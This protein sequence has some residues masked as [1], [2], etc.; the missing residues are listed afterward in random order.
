MMWRLNFLV[1]FCCVVLNNSYMLYY[2]C[3]MH[4]LFTL[5]VYGALGIF[6]KYNEIGS[7]MAAKIIACFFVVILMWEIPG[8]FEVVWSPLT[9]IFGRYLAKCS[10]LLL[11]HRAAGG[12]PNASMYC[13]LYWSCKTRFAPLARVAFSFWPWSLYLDSWNDICLLSSNGK[14]GRHHVIHGS[15]VCACGSLMLRWKW[16]LEYFEFVDR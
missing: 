16:N 14:F 6:S 10:F 9:F 13:R 2:I 11:K 3:P 5:M 8:V 4:T 1:L 12:D 7:V 15:F